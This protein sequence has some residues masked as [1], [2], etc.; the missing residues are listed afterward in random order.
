MA[1]DLLPL[2]QRLAAPGTSTTQGEVQTAVNLSVMLH[3]FQRSICKKFVQQARGLPLLM[4]YTVDPTSFALVATHTQQ[5]DSKTVLRKGKVLHELLMQRMVLKRH[6][7]EGSVPRMVIDYPRVLSQGKSAKHVFQCAQQFLPI[8][9]QWAH[10]GFLVVHLCADGALHGPLADLMLAHQQA[11]DQ[12]QARAE[13]DASLSGRPHHTLFISCPCAA[14]VIQ[15]SLKWAMPENVTDEVLKDLHICVESLRN[16]FSLL[17][18]HLYDF[19]RK[20]LAFRE[21][22]HDHD[23]AR[24]FWCALGVE[25][26]VLQ[27]FIDVHPLWDGLHLWVASDL[28]GVENSITKVSWLMLKVFRWQRFTQSRFLSLGTSSRGLVA[29]MAV[30]LEGL[31]ALTRADPLATDFHLHG[32]SHLSQH[33]RELAVVCAMASYPA[34]SGLQLILADDR[35]AAQHAE[36]WRGMLEEQQWLQELPLQ[37]WSALVSILRL[38]VDAAA[39]RSRCLSASLT[40]LGY[41]HVNL[42][43]VLQSE[44]WRWCIGTHRENLQ[45]LQAADSQCSHPFSQQLRD[46]LQMGGSVDTALAVLSLLQQCSF[47]T[48]GVEQQHGSYATMK[49]HH[50]GYG[51]QSLAARGYLHSC[52][53]LFSPEEMASVLE[54]FQKEQE[55]L[56]RKQPH[57]VGGRSMF[58]QRM[59][60]AEETAVHEDS[61]LTSP[62]HS[63]QLQHQQHR[64]RLAQTLWQTLP[65]AERAQYDKM[66]TAYAQAQKAQLEDQIAELH[67]RRQLYEA[68]QAQDAVQLATRNMVSS[69]RLAS[70]DLDLFFQEFRKC[71]QQ[72]QRFTRRQHALM[73]APEEPSAADMQR[74]HEHWPESKKAEAERPPNWLKTMAVQRELFLHAVIAQSANVHSTAWFVLYIKKSPVEAAVMQMEVALPQELPASCCSDGDQWPPKY[75]TWTFRCSSPKFALLKESDFEDG[76]IFVIPNCFW[77]ENYVVSLEGA[78][79]LQ[80]WQ[81][82]FGVKSGRDSDESKSKKARLT[83]D[84]QEHIANH[85]WMAEYLHAAVPKPHSSASASSSTGEGHKGRVAVRNLEDDDVDELW[86]SLQ[87]RRE[88]WRAEEA[89]VQDHFVTQIRG[90]RW[91]KANLGTVADCVAALAMRG[92]PTT[93]CMQYALPKM[94]SYSFA[95]YGE[96]VAFRLAQEWCARMQH[97]YTMFLLGGDNFRF[98]DDARDSFPGASAFNDFIAGLTP[99]SAQYHRAE[100]LTFLQPTNP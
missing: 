15:N 62:H 45:E 61:V 4:S 36:F 11:L 92:E 52:R 33:C 38:T 99:G 26:D 37:V 20:H 77:C 30:G 65:P 80:A 7:A 100:G 48:M 47:S 63:P 75:S 83:A 35:L 18:G 55:K 70:P 23:A 24:Q 16:S 68:R 72:A 9:G 42:M 90:G 84:M 97:F 82:N 43:R 8:P 10:D 54:K 49:R 22:D 98:P 53:A 64:L 46:Y 6:G 27:Q 40:S 21:G 12:E 44:P 79:E 28:E 66:A 93:F 31:V 5:G 96:R 71:Q 73:D 81:E 95:K 2:L 13:A 59:L 58:L 56:Q 25:A 29:S 74:L 88:T 94:S 60:A 91:T 69:C 14:H 67:T 41:V 34:D 51:L 39:I 57:K 86:A 89:M 3:D 78:F 85:P 17:Q 76:P 1:D 87:S 50:P 19:L 32:F